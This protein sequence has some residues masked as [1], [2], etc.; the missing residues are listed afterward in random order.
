MEKCRKCGGCLAL[1]RDGFRLCLNCH[2]WTDHPSRATPDAE[3][4][5]GE[6][7]APGDSEPSAGDSDFIKVEE[8]RMAK[9]GH[10]II[11]LYVG[12]DG[13]RVNMFRDVEEWKKNIEIEVQGLAAD[14]YPK[15]LTEFPDNRYLHD[16]PYEG[17]WLLDVQIK[18][19]VAVECVTKYQVVEVWE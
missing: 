1:C 7:L 13:P 8:K 14:R 19:P 4:C 15:Y 11:E 18:K 10:Y 17:R 5:G 16:W 12:E 2:N 3:G 9:H 6:K